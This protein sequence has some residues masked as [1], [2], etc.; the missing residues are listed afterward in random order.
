MRHFDSPQTSKQTCME[1]SSESL[2]LIAEISHLV[3]VENY[4]ARL[5]PG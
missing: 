2:I 1:L 5:Y 3:G 4:Q